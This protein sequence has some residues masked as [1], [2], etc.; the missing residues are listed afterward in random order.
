MSKK[1]KTQE[2]LTIYDLNKV[3]EDTKYPVR[4]VCA[5]IKTVVEPMVEP[6]RLNAVYLGVEEM[7]KDVEVHGSEHNPR[8]IMVTKQMGGLAI[9]TIDKPKKQSEH[10]GYGGLILKEIFGDDYSTTTEGDVFKVHLF[11][12]SDLPQQAT[13]I[14]HAA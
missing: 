4:V 12:K 13:S 11:I 7:V 9:D 8:L 14:H 3:K 10:N 1:A 5:A 6:K 2:E